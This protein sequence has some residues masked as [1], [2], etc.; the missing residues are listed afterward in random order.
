MSIHQTAQGTRC[1]EASPVPAT[2]TSDTKT[3]R[4]HRSSAQEL[5][6]AFDF[7]TTHGGKNGRRRDPNARDELDRR[8]YATSGVHMVLGGTPG[9][10]KRR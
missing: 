3:A 7:A 2:E 1:T 6:D 5:H 9:S 8:M 4:L 10:G